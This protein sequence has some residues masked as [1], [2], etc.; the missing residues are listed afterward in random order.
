MSRHAA[1]VVTY[2]PDED[3]FGNLERLSN[4][5]D[6]VI[7]ID[8]TPRPEM[9]RFPSRSNLTVWHCAAN[10]GLASGLNTGM[11][12]AAK[13]GI[14]NIFLFDQDSRPSSQ[15][16]ETMMK[17]KSK[18]DDTSP[19]YA[20]YV[21][22]FYD[23]NSKTFATFPLMGRFS[24]RHVTC[25][26]MPAMADNSALIAIT[27]GMLIT[28]SVYN[29]IGPFREDYFIDFVDNEY[30]LRAGLLGYSIAVNCDLILD[31]AVGR[32]SV[33][34]LFGL[35][36]KPNHHDPVRRYYIFRNGIRTTLDYFRSYPLYA[37]LMTAR[38]SHEVL[39]IVL[40][41]EDK[42]MKTK[43][44]LLGIRHGLKNRM[45]KC[46]MNFLP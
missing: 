7:V 21:P 20:F 35:T 13:Q 22:N 41:E 40:Y 10:M 11:G 43:A 42:L 26:D 8:N 29:R 6:R 27:S 17:F 23:R 32:R 9:E 37:V 28:L 25:R 38:L 34:R 12:L 16:F 44:L 2:F 46:P 4:L 24:L 31:H 30:C 3:A 1:I 5:C 45:G 18:A 14:E 19:R 33:R 15:Y 39:S 36:I